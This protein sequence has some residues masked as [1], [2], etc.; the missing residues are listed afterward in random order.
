MM[1]PTVGMCIVMGVLP[2]VFLRPME[3]SVQRTI[4][5]VTGGSYAARPR[6]LHLV[7]E[8]GSP[9]AP[10]ALPPASRESR[11]ATPGPN[12]PPQSPSS[13]TATKAR[14]ATKE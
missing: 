8:T 7:R 6:L 10:P 2:G 13:A 12:P 11:I 9:A 1:V 3:P 4:E 14:L 5:R